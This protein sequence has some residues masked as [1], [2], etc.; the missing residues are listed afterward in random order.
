MAAQHSTALHLAI[1]AGFTG[2]SQAIKDALKA[3]KDH[4]DSVFYLPTAVLAVKQNVKFDASKATE[5]LGNLYTSVGELGAKTAAD[6]LGVD[7]VASKSVEQLLADRG[8]VLQGISDSALTRMSDAIGQGLTNGQGY[9]AIGDSVNAIIDNTQR[10]D[11]IS[12][13]E[14]NRAFNQA[15]I[16]QIGAAG[17]TEYDWVTDGDPCAECIPEEGTH[18]LDYPPPPLHPNCQCAALFPDGTEISD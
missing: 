10:A 5:A 4:T 18:E 9:R 17:G 7:A 2:V 16:D 1:L 13:T 14:S 3:T 12:I 11:V 15:F 8:F 6:S